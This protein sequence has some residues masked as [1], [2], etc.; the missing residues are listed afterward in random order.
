M[1]RN[2]VDHRR[3]EVR[4]IVRNACTAAAAGIIGAHIALTHLTSLTHDQKW[5]RL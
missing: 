2:G 3:Q 1:N 4:Q 5:R